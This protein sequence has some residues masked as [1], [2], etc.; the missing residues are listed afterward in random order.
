MSAKIY[1]IQIAL[2]GI[3]PKIWRRLLVPS[4]LLLS[5]F[6]K[7]IQTSMG[8]TNSHLHQFIKDNT[9]YS[10][11]M[12][13]D[14]FWDEMDNV[15]YKNMKLSDLLKKEK[16][17]MVYE[18]DFGD[19]WEHDIILEKILPVDKNTKYPVCLAGKMSCPPEDCG[20]VWGYADM[21]EILKDPDHEEYETYVEWLG[22]EFDPEYFDKDLVNQLLMEEEYGCRE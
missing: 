4:D 8:W 7:V 10:A 22:G 19:G 3:K 9:F 16:E 21:L 1:Q 20:G 13:D 5:D 12:Q 6:H 18:Y 14:D 11:R 2:K 17:K 15:D